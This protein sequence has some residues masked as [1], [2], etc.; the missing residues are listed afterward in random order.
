ML[1]ILVN[2]LFYKFDGF[3]INLIWIHLHKKLIVIIRVYNIPIRRNRVIGN[4]LGSWSNVVGSNPAFA[5]CFI[6]EK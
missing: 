1:S 2:A 3:N 6:I 4:S 5:I